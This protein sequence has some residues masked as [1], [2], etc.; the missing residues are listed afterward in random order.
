MCRLYDRENRR[1][2]AA[3]S[4]CRAA[5][6]RLEP[7]T[8]EASLAAPRP[9]SFACGAYLQNLIDSQSSPT[10]EGSDTSA[11]DRPCRYVG[12][13]A[14]HLTIWARLRYP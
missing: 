11:R 10:F 4:I 9:V 13:K 1:Q 6:A 14:W 8:H 5:R 12:P 2:L 7:V 3:S